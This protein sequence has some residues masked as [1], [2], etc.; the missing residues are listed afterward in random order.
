MEAIEPMVGIRPAGFIQKPF[1]LQDL[2]AAL[3]KALH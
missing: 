1:S 2:T 3:E